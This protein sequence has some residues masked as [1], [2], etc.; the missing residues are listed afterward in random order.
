MPHVITD[1]CL[2]DGSCKAVCPVDCIVPG[3]PVE[4]YP[5]YY[6]DPETCIDCGACEAECPYG[7]IFPDSEVP[8]M[9][10]AKGS[11]RLS[12]PLVVSGYTES[13]D[14]F[15]C[16]GKQVHLKAT[17]QLQKDEIVD[18]RLSIKDNAIFFLEGPGYEANK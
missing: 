15:N 4:E 7:A 9:Y 16:Q 18:L 1:L 6:I 5:K 14:G 3:Y 8:N 12:K 2:R 10:I 17:R 11:E 13:Y